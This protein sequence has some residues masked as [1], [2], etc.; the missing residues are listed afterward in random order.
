MLEQPSECADYFS[1][2]LTHN[3]GHQILKTESEHSE[4]GQ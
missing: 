2:L 1:M 4:T 3:V